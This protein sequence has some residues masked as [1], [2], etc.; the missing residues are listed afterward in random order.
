MGP[1]YGTQSRKKKG[2]TPKTLAV[3]GAARQDVSRRRTGP[4]ITGPENGIHRVV[5][6]LERS[7]G[8]W[9]PV[10]PAFALP[11]L[12]VFSFSLFYGVVNTLTETKKKQTDK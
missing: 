12:S 6:F 2:E 11:W 8:N 7:N 4:P 9:R 10:E 3:D 5:P 1:I